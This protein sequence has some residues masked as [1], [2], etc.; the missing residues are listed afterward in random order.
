MEGKAELKG[1][2]TLEQ[3]AEWKSKYGEVFAVS[4]DDSICYLK[5]PSRAVLSAMS[6]LQND[7]IKA[8]EFFLNN[9]WISGDESVKT[10]DEK[11][12][13]VVGQLGNLLQIKAAT[14]E[15]L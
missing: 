2:A 3:I 1:Q 9:C 6:G 5:K 13:G 15:K 11:F 7:A 4:V 10:D 14:L 12:L 8:S